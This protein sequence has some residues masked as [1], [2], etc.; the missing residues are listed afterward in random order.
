[1]T[2]AVRN[3]RLEKRFE[4]WDVDGNGMI[5]R[6][7]LESEA[8]RIVAAFGESPQSPNGRAVVDS[9]RY[10]FDYLAE[11]AGVGP[12]GSLNQDQFLQVIEREVFAGGDAGFGRVVRPMI[13][14][15]LNLCDTDGDGEVS[16]AEFGKWLK[17]VGV[18]PSRA[19]EAFQQIDADGSGHLSVEELVQAVKAYHFGTLEAELLG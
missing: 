8:Q 18:E 5:E 7:D 13:Q 16:E 9:F 2:T 10:T 12:N 1:M 6:S 17:A 19:R 14:A 4:K 11:K 3:T 15:I